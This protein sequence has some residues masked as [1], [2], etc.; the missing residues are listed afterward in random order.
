[1]KPTLAAEI[2][3]YDPELTTEYMRLIYGKELKDLTAEDSSKPLEPWQTNPRCLRSICNLGVK[4]EKKR[5]VRKKRERRD[6][7]K[8]NV[9]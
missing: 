4:I 5:A 6:V 3:D 7:N 9:S 2:R 1:M 8:E